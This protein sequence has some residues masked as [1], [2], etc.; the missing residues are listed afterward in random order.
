MKILGCR[1]YRRGPAVNNH[2][3]L[4]FDDGPHPEFTPMIMDR[5]EQNGGRG[6]FFCTGKNL[7]ANREL[8]REIADRGHLIGNHTYS[9]IHPMFAGRGRLYDEIYRTKSLIEE[10]TGKTN[11]FFR[12]PYG[13]LTPSLFS[14][15]R[16]L[17]L[18]IILWNSNSKDYRLMNEN[19][20]FRKIR[21]DIKAGTI[22]LFHDCKFSNADIDY[23]NSIKALNSVMEV[24]MLK[25]LKPATV[26]ELLGD[27]VR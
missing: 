21:G 4:T 24:V 7:T 18:S 13:F 17:E 12:P 6:T 14:I 16:T 3:A 10:L 27:S 9:H 22:M 2:I 19:A 5:I 15:C 8:A 25:G 26:E 1:I 11:R 20:I 23:S